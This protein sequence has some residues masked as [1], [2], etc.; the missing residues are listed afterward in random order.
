[1]HGIFFAIQIIASRISYEYSEKHLGQLWKVFV[2]CRMRQ[3]CIHRQPALSFQFLFD[4][5]C[6]LGIFVLCRPIDRYFH[7]F[8]CQINKMKNLIY[9]RSIEAMSYGRWGGFCGKTF[10]FGYENVKLIGS[11]VR[12][13]QIFF[14]I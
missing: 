4:C 3:K 7:F 2:S 6:I 8:K 9:I 13:I 10:M 14:M 12:F 1:M 11:T 5:I